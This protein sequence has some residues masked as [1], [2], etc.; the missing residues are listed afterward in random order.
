MALNAT[1]KLRPTVLAMQKR[2]ISVVLQRTES[3]M[4]RTEQPARPAR[5]VYQARVRVRPAAVTK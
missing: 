1:S 5:K 4:S 2:G 3:S